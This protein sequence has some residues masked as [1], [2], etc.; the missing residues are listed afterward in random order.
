VV[1][2]CEE[3]LEFSN[4]M[5]KTE[6]FEEWLPRLTDGDRTTWKLGIWKT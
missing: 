4:V 6:T 1:Q 5:V 2:E 3:N